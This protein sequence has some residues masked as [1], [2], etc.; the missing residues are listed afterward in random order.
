[1]LYPSKYY[2]TGFRNNVKRNLPPYQT[3]E[4]ESGN[5]LRQI[6]AEDA[7]PL[8]VP[9]NTLAMQFANPT[10]EQSIRSCKK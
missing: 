4:L 7:N 5:I 3:S 1:M 2:Y 10:D 6:E 9:L 8:A